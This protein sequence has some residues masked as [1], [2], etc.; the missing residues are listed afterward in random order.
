[1]R[2][3]HSNS[4]TISSFCSLLY[5]LVTTVAGSKTLG[6]EYCDL[7]YVLENSHD[8]KKTKPGNSITKNK[9]SSNNTQ[10]VSDSNI[11]PPL[12]PIP[13]NKISS[14]IP[15]FNRRLAF[16]IVQSLGPL[17]VLKIIPILRKWIE[18]QLLQ[19]RN[20]IDIEAKQ[21]QQ[22]Q[23]QDDENKKIPIKRN[24]NKS[25]TKSLQ[26]TIIPKP[27]IKSL[28]KLKLLT[29]LAFLLGSQKVTIFNNNNNNNSDNSITDDTENSSSS[30][31]STTA[32]ALAPRLWSSILSLHLS[33]FY[34]Q[35]NYYSPIKRIFGL[36]YLFGHK[37]DNNNNNSSLSGGGGGYE[38]LGVLLMAQTIS[39]LGSDLLFFSYFNK[40]I[41]QKFKT[42]IKNSG[43]QN[44]QQ[45]EEDLNDNNKEKEID[46]NDNIVKINSDMTPDQMIT[47]ITST[48]TS[49]TTH[50]NPSSSSSSS[51][52][53]E[54][55]PEIMSYIPPQSRTCVLCME[56]LIDPTT[57]LCGHIFCWNCISEWCRE[58]PECPLCRQANLEQNL[59]PLQ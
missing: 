42:F 4:A 19:E 52:H 34:F 49:S 39:Q 50:K 3:V 13:S 25:R 16:A 58:K 11:K 36:K 56:L 8:D 1:M 45:E 35:G 57:T 32:A 15:S 43:N 29:V 6:E 5:L 23:F 37:P 47:A 44:Q 12:L 22:Q 28:A 59:L 30:S 26:I 38:V 24:K 46:N 18:K 33:I 9:K 21:Q 10:I 2:F 7:F 27:S 54:N 40:F 20:K 14:L 51:I 31:R 55:H 41:L 17:V 53:L 48:S